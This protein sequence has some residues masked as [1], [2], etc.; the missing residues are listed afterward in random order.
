MTPWLTHGETSICVINCFKLLAAALDVLFKD[1][2]P[3]VK[4]IRDILLLF[5][6]EAMS[7]LKELRSQDNDYSSFNDVIINYHICQKKQ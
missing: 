4:D 6:K 2:D 1:K 5:S 3:E 7:L